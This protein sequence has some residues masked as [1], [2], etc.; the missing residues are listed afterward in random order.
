MPGEVNLLRLGGRATLRIAENI[1]KW[2]KKELPGEIG[3]LAEE[4]FIEGA[5][6]VL[7]FRDIKTPI[8]TEGGVTRNVG[9]SVLVTAASKAVFKDK[10]PTPNRLTPVT[11]NKTLFAPTNQTLKSMQTY[12]PTLVGKATAEEALSDH[13]TDVAKGRASLQNMCQSRGVVGSFLNLSILGKMYPDVKPITDKYPQDSLIA[14]RTS[15]QQ[16]ELFTNRDN[17]PTVLTEGRLPNAI[18]GKKVDLILDESDR[19]NILNRLEEIAPGFKESL[20]E[21]LEK[22]MEAVEVKSPK[23]S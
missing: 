3:K 20:D 1:G 11:A 8:S 9:R 4:A 6:Q 10:V 2:G 22:P 13:L 5:A 15:G 23:L 12:P 19:V 16:L 14:T 21:A 17:L 7:D 18:K